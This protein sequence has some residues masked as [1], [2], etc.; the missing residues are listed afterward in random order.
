MG[1]LTRVLVSW[2][3]V[4]LACGLAESKQSTNAEPP[5]DPGKLMVFADEPLV[6]EALGFSMKVPA[7]AMVSTSEAGG[8]TRSTVAPPDNL[9]VMRVETR[10]TDNPATTAL[11][12]AD[13]FL[14]KLL[15]TETVS[16]L[17]SGQLLGSRGKLV[18]STTELKIPG[19]SEPGTRFYVQLPRGGGGGGAGAEKAH[20]I[21]GYTFFKRTPTQ[22]VVFELVCGEAEFAA[23]R[24]LYET[25][26]ASAKFEDPEA[27]SA[28]RRDA[29]K[30]GVAFLG[31]VTE[32][33]LDRAM[34]PPDGHA[35]GAGQSAQWFRLYRPASSGSAEDADERGY[36]SV[37]FFRGTRA[38]IDSRVNTAE[39]SR[40]NPE[41]IIAEISARLLGDNPRAKADERQVIDIQGRYFVSRDGTEEAWS[42]RTAVTDAPGKTPSLFSETG[43]RSD[44]LMTVIVNMPG[45]PNQTI[46]PTVPG[47]GYVSQAMAFLLPR[48]M[49][50][51]GFEGEL[52]FYTYQS[53]T[54]AISLRRDSV[55]REPGASD[56]FRIST[57][58]R[59]TGDPQS[60]LHRATGELIL[61]SLN[62]GVAMEPIELKE[63][64][65]LWKRKG[66]P[67]GKM[68]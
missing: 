63:L 17:R 67:M 55:E 66:L 46:R 40:S 9:Y 4:C 64:A 58:L 25:I 56:V 33:Q 14:K 31:R 30:A 15:M 44:K 65:G 2:L 47:E 22:F 42:V 37:R 32:E 38:Q 34:A 18:D 8:V 50:S 59:D 61:G 57:R 36:R 45:R 19:H 5:A 52:G 24:P 26:V 48:L 49:L 7:G 6:I 60:Y 39:A 54:A 62:D 41:G 20:V 3:T 21:Q 1:T 35:A 51:T 11:Q 29:V 12:A 16:D 23:A 43:T 68:P 13:E 53:S 10:S 27:L 28:K